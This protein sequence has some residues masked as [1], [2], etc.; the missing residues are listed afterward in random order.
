VKAELVVPVFFLQQ[1]GMDASVETQSADIGL[2]PRAFLQSLMSS[3]TSQDDKKTLLETARQL[4]GK[5]DAVYIA[6]LESL[7]KE[8]DSVKGNKWALRR[9]PVPL[10]SYRAKL[11][12]LNRMLEQ[13]LQEGMDENVR[14][15]G[16][17]ARTLAVLLRQ[18]ELTSGVRALESEATK[19]KTEVSMADMLKRTPENLE[20]PMYQV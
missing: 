5:G 6:F 13:L 12:C 14:R 16:V 7:L 1:W 19:A 9:W 17:R 15:E 3:R 11:G 10:P 4:R 2:E 20:T 8:V 18:L